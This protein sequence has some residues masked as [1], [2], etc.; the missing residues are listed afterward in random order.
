MKSGMKRSGVVLLVCVGLGIVVL[1]GAGAQGAATFSGVRW[2]PDFSPPTNMPV[3]PTNLRTDRPTPPPQAGQH[4]STTFDLGLIVWI[5]AGIAA[6]I[7]VLLII[8]WLLRRP[9]RTAETLNAADLSA[10]EEPTEVQEPPEASTPVVRRGLRQAIADLTTEREPHDAIVKAWLGLQ[11]AAEEA[12]VSRRLAET[13]TEFTR[14]ILARVPADTTAVDVL[15]S[16]YLQVR[17]GDHPATDEDVQRVR[18]SLE[19]LADSWESVRQT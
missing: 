3:F 13:P 2:V 16:C 7:A 5:G 12:G 18:L 1:I 19:S 9:P 10:A 4:T 17:F 14:R 15:L 8:R 6:L 11:E